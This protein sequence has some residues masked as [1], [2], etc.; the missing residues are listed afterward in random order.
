MLQLNVFCLI[1]IADPRQ[2]WI[3]ELFK[4][5]LFNRSK[6]W[7]WTCR[8]AS[9]SW[10]FGYQWWAQPCLPPQSCSCLRSLAH[11]LEQPSWSSAILWCTRPP[12]PAQI[13][14]HSSHPSPP[15]SLPKPADHSASK[16]NKT[17]WEFRI[18]KIQLQSSYILPFNFLRPAYLRDWDFNCVLCGWLNCDLSDRI[19][20]GEFMLTLP[21]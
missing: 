6:A 10:N 7:S 19:G 3:I 12:R 11:Q 2:A 5:S 17:Q 18:E 13:R 16:F 9:F 4:L 21:A 8:G 14:L 15:L 20:C 1:G